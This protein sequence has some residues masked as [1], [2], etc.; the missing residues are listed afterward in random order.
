MIRTTDIR[1]ALL[2]LLF[3][4]VCAGC[5]SDLVGPQSPLCLHCVH[6][7]PDTGFG[8]LPGN[9]VE[10]NFW[11]RL[12]FQAA[13]ACYYFTRDSLIQRL[14]HQVKYRGNRDLAIF[15][16]RLMGQ[17]L[18]R[19][20]R[21]A[22]LDMLVPLPLFPARERTRGYNQATL[23]CEGIAEVLGIP[24]AGTCIARTTHTETQTKKARMERWQNITGKFS[25]VEPR[26]IAG[27]HVLLVD[28]VVTTGATLESCGH[29]LLEA[30]DVTLYLAALCYSSR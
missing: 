6:R 24:V 14:M 21:F 13:T 19:T 25:L 30:K 17:N 7:L 2:Q 26:V 18:L 15:L 1:D 20:G 29:T 3:P 22:S 27:R 4:H 9:P 23:L 12:P 28:D 10:K 8:I 5:G 16:G 11:G